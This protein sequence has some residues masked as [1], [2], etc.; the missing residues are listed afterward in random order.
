MDDKTLI[1]IGLS[2]NQARSYRALVI[3]K[4][5][6]PSELSRLIGESRTNSYAILDK[7]TDMNLA[8]KIDENKKFTY[9][10]ASPLALK[11]MLEK[12]HKETER[13]LAELDR[14]MPQMMSTYQLGGQA[15]K[16][17]HY[18]GKKELEQMYIKQM[19]QP[20]RELF[21]IRSKA[22]VPFFSYAKM[23]E[24]RLLA[25]K[26]KKHRFG[27]TPIVFYSPNDPRRDS[28]SS[29]KRAWINHEEYL[30][31]VEWVVSGDQVQAIL[32]NNEGYG[33]TIDHPEIAESF[34][35][36][37]KLLFK[38]IK[39]SPDYNKLPKLAKVDIYNK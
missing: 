17:T 4:S 13:K 32:L 9:Y 25:P 12:Q 22:D 30:S 20:G 34:R 5:L 33:I 16:V 27:I 35:E 10:P 39:S 14:K 6:K 26:Y 29:L 38:Y 28:K 19:E 8:T 18:K 1:S 23:N 11:E 3:R 21:F 37:L 24:I 2:Q 31:P 7:L 36:I 15:P